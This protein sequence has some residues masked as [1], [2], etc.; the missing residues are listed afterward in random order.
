MDYIY[1]LRT[2]IGEEGIRNTIRYIGHVGFYSLNDYLLDTY[3]DYKYSGRM[4]HGNHKTHF[5]NLGSNDTYHT[6]YSAMPLIFKFIQIKPDDVLVDVGCGKGRVINYWLNMECKND[7]IGLE[8]DPDIAERTA[9]Q[10]T[11]WSNVKIIQGDAVANLPDNGTLFY[12]YNP[13]S[14]NIVRLFERKVAAISENRPVN[15]IYYNP[16]S[17]HI[18]DN[19]NWDIKQINFER[20]LGVKRWGRLNKYHDL[21]LISK[22][23]GTPLA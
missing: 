5:K 6:S 11:K 2:R 16:K 17:V 14:E 1:R 20:D 21:A 10:F 15:I 8:L 4:L 3:L 18:F 13:F 12:F 9:R 23:A 19:G 22:K 7:I